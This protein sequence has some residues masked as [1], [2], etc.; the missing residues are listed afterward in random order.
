[1][2]LKMR[3]IYEEI[4]QIIYANLLT[5]DDIKGKEAE[6]LEIVREVQV[7]GLKEMVR[8]ME[9]NEN[10]WFTVPEINN[11]KLIADRVKALK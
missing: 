6:V 10:G 7:E 5:I 11:R 1:M 2:G 9:N 4:G 8:M 3:N